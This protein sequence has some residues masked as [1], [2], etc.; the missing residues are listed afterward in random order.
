MTYIRRRYYVRVFVVL[1]LS[2]NV[3][4]PEYENRAT[5]FARRAQ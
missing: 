5:P 1:R 2:E 3:K 4:Y